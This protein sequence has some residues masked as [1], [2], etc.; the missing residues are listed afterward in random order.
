MKN[1][2]LIL[3]VAYCGLFLFA[4]TACR[5]PIGTSAKSTI[6]TEDSLHL[7]AHYIQKADT[8]LLYPMLINNEN[9]SL[10]LTHDEERSLNAE[11]ISSTTL[12]LIRNKDGD[13]LFTATYDFNNIDKLYNPA[14]NCYWLGLI[15]SGGGSG[16]TGTLFNIKLE[17]KPVLQ[18]ILNFGELTYWRSNKNGSAILVL[19]GIWKRFNDLDTLDFESHFDGHKQTVSIY[20]LKKDTAICQK[21]GI[22]KSKYS[23]WETDDIVD[24]IKANEPDLAKKIDWQDYK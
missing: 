20:T 5:Q 9:Y 7:K 6:T 12:R 15:N 23:P 1:F 10:K 24:Q 14:P 22:T 8:G 16:Y 3:K 13:T 18:P 19:D 11:N 21:L 17:P 2:K 4:L